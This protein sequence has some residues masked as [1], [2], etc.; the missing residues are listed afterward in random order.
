[1]ITG[2]VSDLSQAL[3]TFLHE[4]NW[5]NDPIKYLAGLLVG[6]T[7]AHKKSNSSYSGQTSGFAYDGSR[8]IAADSRALSSVSVDVSQANRRSDIEADTTVTSDSEGSSDCSMDDLFDIPFD[9][10]AD[11]ADLSKHHGYRTLRISNDSN[12]EEPFSVSQIGWIGDPLTPR[13]TALPETVGNR[14]NPAST[15]HP[16]SSCLRPVSSWDGSFS[17]ML[18]SCKRPEPTADEIDDTT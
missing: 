14:E 9:L 3:A 2:S 6:A 15:A 5:D 1:M 13:E 17:S 8:N 4:Q 7:E 12:N 18:W 10:I 11:S 16:I